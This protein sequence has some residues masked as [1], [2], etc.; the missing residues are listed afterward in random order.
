AKERLYRHGTVKAGPLPQGGLE[1]LAPRLKRPS[2]RTWIARKVFWA[3]AART[4]VDIAWTASPF[5][6][7]TFGPTPARNNHVK[8]SPASPRCTCIALRSSLRQPRSPRS[9]RLR[10]E[11]SAGISSPILEFTDAADGGTE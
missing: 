3:V 10:R 8:A 9:A 2:D 11:P 4:A 1:G 5:A 6:C 7:T